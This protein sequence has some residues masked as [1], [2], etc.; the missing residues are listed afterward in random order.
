MVQS[1]PILA[2]GLITALV[3]S[4]LY[5]KP[6]VFP[7]V[8][9]AMKD[10]YTFG[11][12]VVLQALFGGEGLTETPKKLKEIFKNK[13]AKFVLLFLIAFS[14]TQDIE[15]ALFIVLS[16]LILMQLFR[17]KEERKKHPYLI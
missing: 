3:G 9:I 5:A 15:Q 14:G 8:E 16:F 12:I 10:S 11:I 7:S 6:D 13:F 1:T 17:T 2:G 4:Y